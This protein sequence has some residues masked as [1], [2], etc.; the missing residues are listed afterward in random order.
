MTLGNFTTTLACAHDLTFDYSP[1][2]RFPIKLGPI[3]IFSLLSFVF[4]AQLNVEALDSGSLLRCIF[5][6]INK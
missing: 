6:K 5:L 1:L 2:G 4:W 3:S